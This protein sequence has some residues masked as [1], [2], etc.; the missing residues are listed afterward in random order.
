MKE[1]KYIVFIFFFIILST[2]A[3]AMYHKENFWDEKINQE[4]GQLSLKA[5]TALNFARKIK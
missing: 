2:I 3:I 5:D 4:V 1:G